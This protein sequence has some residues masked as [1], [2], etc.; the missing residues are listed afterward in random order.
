MLFSH[1]LM[2]RKMR[3][4]WTWYWFF[5]PPFRLLINLLLLESHHYWPL[6]TCHKDGLGC[7]PGNIML[8][9]MVQRWEWC[10]SQTLSWI[11][12]WRL[13]FCMLNC[14]LK[15]IVFCCTQ[16]PFF[17]D[18]EET[19]STPKA[20]ALFIPRENP[21]ALVIRPMEQSPLRTSAEKAASPLKDISTP[22]HANGK[23]CYILFHL[24]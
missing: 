2:Q 23:S 10:F 18:D 1:F 22:V 24:A 11:F 13:L 7:L 19:P 16:V 17:S 15:L 8:R 4:V 5:F 3:W 14:H 6:D 9:M 21:R 20:D 12:E